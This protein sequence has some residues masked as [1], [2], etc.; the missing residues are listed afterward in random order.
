MAKIG[1][2]LRRSPDAA[3]AAEECG[4]HILIRLEDAMAAGAPATLAISGG[5]SPHPM[6]KFFAGQDFPWDRVHVFWVDERA[7]PPTDEQSNFKWAHDLW[8]G[9]ARVPEGNVHRVLAEFPPVEAARRYVADIR[10]F[11][12][13][14]EGD[15]PK[16]EVIHLGMGPDAHTAS[17]F[18]GSPSIKDREHI[19]TPLWVE[20][21]KQWRITLLPGVIEAARHLCMLVTGADKV[22]AMEAVLQGPHDPVRYPAQLAAREGSG[23]VWFADAAAAAGL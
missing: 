22:A 17:L 19:A 9:P 2:E 5:S 11:F 8:L 23:A 1:I 18:P 21:M 7:V 4:R 13:L 15:L 14:A 20:G 16:F 10:V 6:F 12:G 3:A